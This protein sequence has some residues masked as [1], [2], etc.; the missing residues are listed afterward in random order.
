MTALSEVALTKKVARGRWTVDR[1]ALL[2]AFIA[3][4]RGPG[5]T[6]RYF[7]SLNAPGQSAMTVFALHDGQKGKTSCVI[8]ADVAADLIAPHRRPSHLLIYVTGNS[9]RV[10]DDWVE[11]HGAHDAN[12]FV[13]N[14]DDASVAGFG[15]ARPLGKTNLPLAD[16]TQILWDLHD[17]GGEDRL[18]VA[19]KVRKWILQHQRTS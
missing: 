1:E 11:A 15:F 19:E 12:I 18:E 7:S 8:S 2:D 9:F 16:P 10:P 6:T 14:A 17:M 5:G 4:Y 13:R 3:Q